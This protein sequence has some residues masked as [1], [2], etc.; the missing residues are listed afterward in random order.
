VSTSG[1]PD[2]A[3]EEAA[4]LRRTARV[5]R[6][7]AAKVGEAGFPKLADEA[8]RNADAAAVTAALIEVEQDA[9]AGAAEEP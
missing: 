3:I 1:D 7:R 5:Q 6:S 8:T 4:D 2:E 9:N